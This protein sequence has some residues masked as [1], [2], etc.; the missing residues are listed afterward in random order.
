MLPVI[1]MH[2]Q[3]VADKHGMNHPETV[4][5]TDLFTSISEELSVHMQKEEECFSRT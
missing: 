5:I 1:Y 3:K 2:S 4:Q